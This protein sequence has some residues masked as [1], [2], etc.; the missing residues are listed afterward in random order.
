MAVEQML[1][2]NRHPQKVFQ[3]FVRFRADRAN[4]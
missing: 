2:F 4:R 1:C 3:Q